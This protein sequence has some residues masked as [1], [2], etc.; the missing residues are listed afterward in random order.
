MG[1]PDF[2]ICCLFGAAILI[3]SPGVGVTMAMCQPWDFN[4]CE[5]ISLR[6][7]ESHMYWTGVIVQMSCVSCQIWVSYLTGEQWF[8]NLEKLGVNSLASGRPGCHFKTAI[9]NL[10]L[11]IGILTSS[12]DDTLRW[13][14]RNLM[15]NKSTLV[16]VM[17]WCRQTTSHYLSQCW[18]RSLPIYGVTRPQWVNDGQKIG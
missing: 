9:F 3:K 15:D 5:S 13:M 7:M 8:H 2:I 17:A 16:Q 11:L 4:I 6:S 10:V 18:P 12:K 14:P 1:H